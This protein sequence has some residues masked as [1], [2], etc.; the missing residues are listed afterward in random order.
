MF[1]HRVLISDSRIPFPAQCCSFPF[2]YNTQL[3]YQCT[4]ANQTSGVRGCLLPH[5]VW[6]ECGLPLGMES[7]NV[8]MPCSMADPGMFDLEFNCVCGV[9]SLH[10]V[11]K[12][13]QVSRSGIESHQHHR[14]NGKYGVTWGM[15]LCLAALRYLLISSFDI[16][17][18]VAI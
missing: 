16:T 6:V 5:R 18:I 14:I 3:Y 17:H 1:S 13:K 7:M 12:S 9:V 15:K 8:S 11:R 10:V 2:T 4:T